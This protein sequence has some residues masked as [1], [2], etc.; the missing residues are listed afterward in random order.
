MFESV[1]AILPPWLQRPAQEAVSGSLEELRLRTGQ[2]PA[3]VVRGREMPLGRLKRVDAGDLNH[4]LCAASRASLYA[5]NETL[6]HGFLTLP[7]GHRIGICGQAVREQGS[8][9]TIHQIS[10][11]A[12]RFARE[13]RWTGVMPVDSCLIL[14][15]PGCGKTTLLR[16]CIRRLSDEGSFRVS[17]VDERGEVAACVGGVPQFSVGAHTDVLT[18]TEKA[19][20]I[21]MLLRTMNPQWIAVDE[22]TRTE[23]ILAISQA[24]YCGVKLLATAHADKLSDLY[25][26]P[27]YTELM[28][29]KVF[30]EVMILR[31]DHSFTQERLMN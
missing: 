5:V 11:M 15:P 1:I 28:A 27:V 14:G 13:Q 6:A 30:Q 22:I 10:S 4:I 9:R 21:T 26:R 3:C 19:Q 29:Q 20:G 31:P 25:K 18:A 2:A 16:D 23:D 24:A 7:G 8:I 12:I 17:L